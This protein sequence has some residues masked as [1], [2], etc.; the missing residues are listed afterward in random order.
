MDILLYNMYKNIEYNML[1]LYKIN[2][3]Y[4]ILSYLTIYK[5][6]SVFYSS[7]VKTIYFYF[8]NKVCV[9]KVSFCV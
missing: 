3:K 5:K 6:I 7:N 8:F 9:Y 1:I 4:S 2:K